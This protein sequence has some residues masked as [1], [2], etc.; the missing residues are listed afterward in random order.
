MGN[1]RQTLDLLDLLF[2]VKV[3]WQCCYQEGCHK[4]SLR[5]LT[6]GILTI[7]IN[8]LPAKKTRGNKHASEE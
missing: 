8:F 3:G 2:I 4:V 1:G 5:A 6:P 7:S